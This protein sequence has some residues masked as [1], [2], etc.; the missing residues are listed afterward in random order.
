MALWTL[1]P[2]NI[3]V[4]VWIKHYLTVCWLLCVFF[5]P[6]PAIHHPIVPLSPA[7]FRAA[8]LS[9]HRSDSQSQSYS[10]SSSSP[11]CMYLN[12]YT[13]I[14]EFQA[15][16]N[17]YLFLREAIFFSTLNLHLHAA[18]LVPFFRYSQWYN[19]M[20]V[21]AMQ[22]QKVNITKTVGLCVAPIQCIHTSVWGLTWYSDSQ[23]GILM[24]MLYKH[25]YFWHEYW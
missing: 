21:S 8:I 17:V 5:S 24:V 1:L 15:L 18:H 22:V 19:R 14:N 10:G 4:S 9:L 3:C 13:Y 6:K 25:L 7:P 16:S 2:R 20:C 12:Y 11:C 23:H